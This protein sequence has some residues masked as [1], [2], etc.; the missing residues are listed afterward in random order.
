MVSVLVLRSLWRKKSALPFHL[1]KLRGM[2]NQNDAIKIVADALATAMTTKDIEVRISF[3]TVDEATL[4]KRV[5]LVE[6]FKHQQ[7]DHMA[8]IRGAMDGSG[9]PNLMELI[10]GSAI[11]FQL[12]KSVTGGK[13]V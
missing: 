12:K 2:M 6:L 13:D 9:D 10:N 8:Q 11:R 7:L 5:V 4:Y 3:D 1:W